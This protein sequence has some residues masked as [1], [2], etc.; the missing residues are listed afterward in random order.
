MISIVSSFEKI[1]ACKS[2]Y[3]ANNQKISLKI[4]VDSKSLVLLHPAYK[5]R[6]VHW[7]VNKRK[8]KIF[9]LK[10]LEFKNNYYFCRPLKTESFIK[11]RVREIK[12]KYFSEIICRLKKS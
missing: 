8:N 1:V 2:V 7:V 10:C 9:S 11:H 3:L 12:I 5:E 4:L 6:V